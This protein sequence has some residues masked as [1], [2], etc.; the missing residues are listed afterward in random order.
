MSGVAE[1]SKL[2]FQQD[3]RQV[4]RDDALPA[5][6]RAPKHL[7]VR[8]QPRGEED[9]EVERSRPG[10]SD[11]VRLEVVGRGLAR[12][13]RGRDRHHGA[14]SARRRQDDL[15][16]VRFG[17]HH[18]FVDRRGRVDQ[19]RIVV[20]EVLRRVPAND[21]PAQLHHVIQNGPAKRGRLVVGLG[22]EAQGRPDAQLQP[23][24]ALGRV[25]RLLHSDQSRL[26]TACGAGHKHF[27]APAAAR[28][29]RQRR[30]RGR[31]VLDRRVHGDLEGRAPLH[32]QHD[33]G[34]PGRQQI[35]RV[36]P[37][38]LQLQRERRPRVVVEANLRQPGQALEEPRRQLGQPVP[39][40]AQRRKPLQLLEDPWEQRSD[41]VS[42]QPDV[43]DV[44]RSGE[45]AV[46]QGFDLVAS[47]AR[48]LDLVGV[49]QE[50]RRQPGQRVAAHVDPPEPSQPGKGALGQ[51]GDRVLR[52]VELFQ[53][54][55]P[56][57]DAFGQRIEPVLA[58]V[59][60]P[61]DRKPSEDAFGQR[62][63]LV[64]A[65]VEELKGRKSVEVADLQGRRPAAGAGVRPT[66]AQLVDLPQVVVGHRSAAVARFRRQDDLVPYS[67]RAVAYAFQDRRRRRESGA[68]PIVVGFVGGVQRHDDDLP[69]RLDPIVVHDG[70]ANDA[71]PL[72]RRDL[73]RALGTAGVVRRVRVGGRV[74]VVGSQGVGHR[75][76]RLGRRRNRDRQIDLRSL[77]R[78]GFGDGQRH[79]GK[80]LRRRR[81]LG[82]R[83]LRHGRGQRLDAVDLC[84]RPRGCDH[85]GA[86]ADVGGRVHRPVARK[87]HLDALHR[88]PPGIGHP[89]HHGFGQ[90]PAGPA[91]LSVARHRLHRRGALAHR[92]RRRVAQ[93][94]ER[95]DHR[96]RAVRHRHDHAVGARLDHLP[97]A[98]G[99]GDGPRVRR[100]V[101]VRDRR[102]EGGGRA[103]MPQNH[104]IRRHRQG[105]GAGR[106]GLGRRRRR[107]RIPP[108][109]GHGQCR[110]Q[111]GGRRRRRSP[112]ERPSRPAPRKHHVQS[113]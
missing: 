74:V 12:R 79:H 31:P 60:D 7:L 67:R 30:G 91:L 82:R 46:G 22:E 43:G 25:G 106:L 57:E 52:Q 42:L 27:G 35:R 75:E 24:E 65:Q 2:A 98:A 107:G 96:R 34:R 51:L 54:V 1:A 95:R 11:D 40:Q 103:Q 47:E 70:D 104:G 15:P 38:Q 83:P 14:A 111:A 66:H 21:W 78:G 50:A 69:R 13:V 29:N 55:Q 93:P 26:S 36:G 85:A 5:T 58:Q 92:R 33:A 109:G 44:G 68:E 16:A 73:R 81:D 71:R 72:A 112:G 102:N 62:I 61:K 97:V 48:V 77:G 9:V 28:W 59:E 76:R 90:R 49:R 53:G 108:A 17:A 80:R 41:P 39:L 88:R 19:G 56:S 64:P 3:L 89:D 20:R 45:E 87:G 86:V 32:L 100:A 84:Q 63:E 94:L 37:L 18:A 23:R 110:Q 113:V 99:P 101:L 105:N 4:A 8:R 6:G 10:R